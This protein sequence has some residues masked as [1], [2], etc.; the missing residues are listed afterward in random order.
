MDDTIKHWMKAKQTDKCIMLQRNFPP[1]HRNIS[2]PWLNECLNKCFLHSL[3]LPLTLDNSFSLEK[4]QYRASRVCSFWNFKVHKCELNESCF[5]FQSNSSPS[6]VRLLLVFHF[7][8]W[9]ISES[10]SSE[11][12]AFKTPSISNECIFSLLLAMLLQKNLCRARSF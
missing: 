5:V 8:K 6:D 11:R 10:I 12:G 1:F 4:K 3:T 7:W 2:G 9:K